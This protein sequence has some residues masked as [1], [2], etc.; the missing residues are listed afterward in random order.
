MIADQDL[1][2]LVKSNE[3]FKSISE[4]FIKSFIN[5]KN[6]ISV[7]DGTLIYSFEDEASDF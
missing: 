6:F 2:K 7:K 5:P 4:F 1:M 3:I